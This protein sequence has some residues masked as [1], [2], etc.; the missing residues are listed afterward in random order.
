M[1]ALL[2][3]GPSR[4]LGTR[5]DS[6]KRRE[7]WEMPRRPCVAV[8]P[9][10]LRAFR[11][12]EPRLRF[13]V[14][15]RRPACSTRGSTS[16]FHVL[17]KRRTVRRCSAGCCKAAC[18]MPRERLR[19]RGEGRR[20]RQ[21]GPHPISTSKTP[22]PGPLSAG[23]EGRRARAMSFRVTAKAHPLSRRPRR[24]SQS[25]ASAR[26]ACLPGLAFGESCFARHRERTTPRATEVFVARLRES[27]VVRR[28]AVRGRL[29]A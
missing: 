19:A 5:G 23:G 13:P 21:R 27:E 10:R 17:L 16:M 2:L 15:A 11:F 20:S 14:G 28:K 22:P 1:R 25:T 12:T 24:C 26:V 3:Q 8:P 4:G 9:R 7:S 18:S 29:A 6:F